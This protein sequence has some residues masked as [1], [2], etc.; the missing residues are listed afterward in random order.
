MLLEDE[1]LGDVLKELANLL[2]PKAMER[3]YSHLNSITILMGKLRK[4]RDNWRKKY[5][6]LKNGTKSDT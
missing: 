5:E 2:N 4:S 3:L 6:L 1:E